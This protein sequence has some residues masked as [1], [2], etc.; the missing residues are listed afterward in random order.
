MKQISKTKG[1]KKCPWCQE[2]VVY[3]KTGVNLKIHCIEFE[4]SKCGKSWIEP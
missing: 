4:C 3:G 2:P 1:T